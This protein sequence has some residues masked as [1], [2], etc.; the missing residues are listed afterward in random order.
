MVNENATKI[1]LEGEKRGLTHQQMADICNVKVTSIYRWKKVGRAKANVIVKL[2]KYLEQD[3]D[4][5]NTGDA[6]KNKLLNDANL[7][8]LSRRARELG[9]R[10][11]FTDVS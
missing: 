11:S 10:A 8:D 2:E 5:S 4:L 7:E 6:Y 9:F 1:V 3:A